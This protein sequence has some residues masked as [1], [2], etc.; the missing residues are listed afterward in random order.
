M[1]TKK[2]VV[3]VKLQLRVEDESSGSMK[4]KNLN[5]NKVKFSVTDEELLTAGKAIADLQT[6]A[7]SGVRSVVS[8]DLMED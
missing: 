5:F 7:L 3:D 1:A 2:N 4:I 6:R 8:G